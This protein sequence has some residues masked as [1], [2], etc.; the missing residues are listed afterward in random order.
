MSANPEALT[1]AKLYTV[2]TLTCHAGF[3]MWLIYA[4][5]AFTA[6]GLGIALYRPS[7]LMWLIL[8]E[9]LKITVAKKM[10]G[11]S[12]VFSLPQYTNPVRGDPSKGPLLRRLVLRFKKFIF[13]LK[14]L[15]TLGNGVL[16][17][18]L[19]WL[20]ILYVT[21]CF[22][23]PVT[24]DY[25]ETLGFTLLVAALTILP[26]I[27]MYGPDLEKLR[28]VTFQTELLE[29]DIIGHILFQNALGT[30]IGAWF[31]AFPIPLD[32]DRPWQAWPITCCLG[33]CAG[34]SVSVVWS[35]L[36]SHWSYS[37]FACV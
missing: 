26:S 11:Y 36:Q 29:T 18:F 16:V 5:D 6:R 9:L 19:G 22:G 24:T 27:L 33:A 23:A 28:K 12:E 17:L 30:I 31:G 37:R 4:S 13:T 25:V 2:A 3:V 32:W 10:S 7:S 14:P 35:A 15:K 1:F 34:H 21:V 8:A 20:L